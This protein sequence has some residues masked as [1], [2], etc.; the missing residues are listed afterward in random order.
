M[1]QNF[2]KTQNF[3][4]ETFLVDNVTDFSHFWKNIVTVFTFQIN[5]ALIR[6]YINLNY[7]ILEA[8]HIYDKVCLF[9]YSLTS[10]KW[11]IKPVSWEYSCDKG[12][13]EVYDKR[14]NW[15]YSFLLAVLQWN[16]LDPKR[17]LFSL[18]RQFLDQ[19]IN[20]KN[21][22]ILTDSIYDC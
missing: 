9:P 7:Q 3:Y 2:V 10:I 11:G 13:L 14:K 6:S 18:V 5:H 21:E 12:Y 16:R 17:I 8:K 22:K 19:L 20:C 15:K 1:R 4:I